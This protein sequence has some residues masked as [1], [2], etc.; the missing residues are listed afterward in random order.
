MSD[1]KVRAYFWWAYLAVVIGCLGIVFSAEAAECEPGTWAHPINGYTSPSVGDMC[2]WY[3]GEVA[4]TP[5]TCSVDS[6]QAVASITYNGGPLELWS[7][8][9]GSPSCASDPPDAPASGASGGAPTER[10]DLATSQEVLNALLLGLVFFA[11][12]HGYS[13]GVRR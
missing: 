11:L 10:A 6:A 1:D 5:F 8:L 4:G 9:G 2:V 7:R 12:V 13:V 3:A